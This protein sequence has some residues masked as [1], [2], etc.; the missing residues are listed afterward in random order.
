VGDVSVGSRLTWKRGGT[1]VTPDSRIP[2]TPVFDSSNDIT[3]DILFGEC[4]WHTRGDGLGLCMVGFGEWSSGRWRRRSGHGEKD[5]IALMILHMW[6]IL[7]FEAQNH[8]EQ[9]KNI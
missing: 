1:F 3:S 7:V 6:F 5:I 9:I 2:L 4:V 8:L